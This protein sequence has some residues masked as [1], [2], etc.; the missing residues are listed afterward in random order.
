[1]RPNFKKLSA[2]ACTRVFKMA[3]PEVANEYEAHESAIQSVVD[4]LIEG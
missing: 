2:L 4:G 1:M 3:A